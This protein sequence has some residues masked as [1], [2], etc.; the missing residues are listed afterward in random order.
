MKELSLT[1]G[2][3]SI[4]SPSDIHIFSLNNILSTGITLLF[5]FSI[6]L[7]LFFL[8][9]GGISFIT[10]GGDKQ[11]VVNARHKLTFAVVGLIVVLFS[12]FIVNFIGQLFGVEPLG[13]IPT[14][15]PVCN[16]EGTC[17]TP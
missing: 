15:P 5:T 17:I 9:Y 6:I 11:K 16:S 10:S 1:V 13:H 4:Q 2:Q 7:T 3:Y 12:F 14:T 8:I